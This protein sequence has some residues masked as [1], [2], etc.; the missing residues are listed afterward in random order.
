MPMITSESLVDPSRTISSD[1]AEIGQWHW[2]KSFRVNQSRSESFKVIW[3]EEHTNLPTDLSAANAI[4]RTRTMYMFHTMHVPTNL[5]RPTNRKSSVNCQI[6]NESD[7]ARTELGA[8]SIFWKEGSSFWKKRPARCGDWW[9]TSQ[10]MNLIGSIMNFIKFIIWTSVNIRMIRKT[11]GLKFKLCIRFW[12]S[13]ITCRSEAIARLARPF[14]YG[15]DESGWSTK[16]SSR[17]VRIRKFSW[18]SCG[19]KIKIVN[20]F[21]EDPNFGSKTCKTSKLEL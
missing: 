9:F 4:N 19:C 10:F 5:K 14:F 7:L 18:F 8:F 13:P 16:R 20:V 2:A 6:S 21:L 3:I 12:W 1:T 15:P 17:A 11:F